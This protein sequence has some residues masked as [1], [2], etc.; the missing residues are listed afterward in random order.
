[1]NVARAYAESLSLS[2]AKSAAHHL[3]LGCRKL[4][5]ALSSFT[6]VVIS[7]KYISGDLGAG[8]FNRA[9]AKAHVGQHNRASSRRVF[10]KLSGFRLLDVLLPRGGAST[11]RASS[12]KLVRLHA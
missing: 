8:R 11:Q 6:A 10:A 7:S 4:R 12:Q 5:L 3:S 9:L 1:M 2:S